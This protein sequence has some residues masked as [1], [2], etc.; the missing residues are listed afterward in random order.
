LTIIEN[1]ERGN[2]EEGLGPTAA[3]QQTHYIETGK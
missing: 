2:A 3:A 1:R